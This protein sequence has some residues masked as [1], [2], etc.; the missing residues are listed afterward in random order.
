MLQNYFADWPRVQQELFRKIQQSQQADSPILLADM[1]GEL[2]DLKKTA[3]YQKIAG[4]RAL[5]FHELLIIVDFF[6]INLFDLIP[7]KKEDRILLKLED[8]LSSNQLFDQLMHFLQWLKPFENNE[9][10]HIFISAS[11]TPL[12]LFLSHPT[13][14]LWQHCMD[15]FLYEDNKE[16]VTVFHQLKKNRKIFSLLERIHQKL[17]AC[18]LSYFI[19]Q[20]AFQ[21]FID[22][23]EYVERLQ[24]IG[25]QRTLIRLFLSFL[26]ELEALCSS[27]SPANKKLNV[28]L[29]EVH[30]LKSQIL[31]DNGE[32]PNI[33]CYP[34]MRGQFQSQSKKLIRGRQDELA[35]IRDHAINISGHNRLMRSDFF[36]HNLYKVRKRLGEI[37]HGQKILD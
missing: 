34:F 27:K 26:E 6:E 3:S 18:H 2:L 1:I 20:N 29:C 22:R 7:D 24:L 25:E 36:S 35:A 17:S 28:F 15:E 37:P 32:Q 8:Q 12:L 19:T 21:L 14:F 11:T 13:L 23:I 33:I 9:A 30:E 10:G 16:W 5:R 31:F 4:K